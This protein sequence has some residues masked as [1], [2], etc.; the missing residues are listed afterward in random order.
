MT[1]P[2]QLTLANVLIDSLQRESFEKIVGAD[3]E[4]EYM[5]TIYPAHCT[6]AGMVEHTEVRV[7]GLGKASGFRT[8]QQDR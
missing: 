4:S 5:R 2:R 6:D 3:S 7:D 1:Q 8:I